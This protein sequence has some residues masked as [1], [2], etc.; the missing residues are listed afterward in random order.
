MEE[1]TFPMRINKYLALK[2]YST[3]R[4]AD[5]IIRKKQVFINGRLAVLGDKVQASDKVEVKFRGKPPA[6][7][8][9]AFNKPKGMAITGEKSEP[10]EEDE[11]PDPLEGGFPIGALDKESYGLMLITNDGRL[12]ERLLS[13]KYMHEKEYIVFTR[14]KIRSNFKQKMEAGVE[15]DGV[16]TKKC[17]VHLI[18]DNAFRVIFSDEKRHQLRRM[19]A[20]LFQEIRYIEC[21]R[22]MNIALGNLKEGARREIKG[23][24][25]ALFLKKLGLD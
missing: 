3:R 21:V 14:D 11:E 18:D 9:Y 25:L 8:Y 20:E 19:C 12:T 5:E 23:E 24:E 15:I 22:I 6:L 10:R 2:K 13:P 7:V 4:G 17:R 1:S 16:L